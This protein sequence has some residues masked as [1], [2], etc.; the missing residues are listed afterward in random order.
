MQFEN[1]TKN[2][3]LHILQSFNCKMVKNTVNGILIMLCNFFEYEIVEKNEDM[4][5]L[6]A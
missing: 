5:Q 3:H 6:K 1:V 2:C 4:Y